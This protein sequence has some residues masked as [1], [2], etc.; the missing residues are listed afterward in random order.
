MPDD[1][2]MTAWW[3]SDDCLSDDCVSN[4][5]WWLRSDEP[6]D[7]LMTV[8]WPADDFQMTIVLKCDPKAYWIFK[9][10][11][12]SLSQNLALIFLIFPSWIFLD[13]LFFIL[14]F[15]WAR[16]FSWLTSKASQPEPA[17]LRQLYWDENLFKKLGRNNMS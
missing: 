12:H 16:F 3:T 10:L 14:L 2:L 9:T 4:F 15:T 11:W 6:D 5:V 13:F 1:F 17:K 7:C 8:C